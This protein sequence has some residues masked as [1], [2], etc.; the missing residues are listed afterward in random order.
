MATAE[1]IGQMRERAAADLADA[2]GRLGALL[3]LPEP[4]FPRPSR[5][6]RLDHARWLAAVAAYLH[7][8]ADAVAARPAPPRATEGRRTAA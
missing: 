2:T 1:A 6:P 4:D 5:D 3:G 7:Q 8:V